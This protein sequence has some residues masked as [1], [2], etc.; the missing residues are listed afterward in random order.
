MHS[1]P[2]SPCLCGGVGL[3]GVIYSQPVPRTYSINRLYVSLECGNRYVLL[4]LL[5][6]GGFSEVWRAFD[7]VLA[8]EVAVKVRRARAPTDEL[9]ARGAWFLKRCTMPCQTVWRLGLLNSWLK[10]ALLEALCFSTFA[11][12]ATFAKC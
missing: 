1:C 4:N 6:K 2:V 12:F 7:L 9:Q 3:S 10:N 11:L 8:E 5:G